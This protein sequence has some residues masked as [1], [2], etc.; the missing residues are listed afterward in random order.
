MKILNCSNILQFSIFLHGFL[1]ICI[2]PSFM[3]SIMLF[4]SFFFKGN[5]WY[6]LKYQSLTDY[7]NF[8]FGPRKLTALALKKKIKLKG[9][10]YF[11]ELPFPYINPLLKIVLSFS[12][13][14]FSFNTLKENLLSNL[15]SKEKITWVI[16]FK[17]M[18]YSILAL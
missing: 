15:P 9:F 13:R 12:P 2:S 8:Q 5:C 16:S 3:I 11:Q 7:L 1:A 18:Q 4:V 14:L 17:W 10:S 6:L